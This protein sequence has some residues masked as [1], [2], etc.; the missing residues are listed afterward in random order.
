MLQRKVTDAND[1][2]TQVKGPSTQWPPACFGGHK[3]NVGPGT[4]IVFG[5]FIIKVAKLFKIIS[6]C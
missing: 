5:L 1:Q 6:N 3:G 4:F 2:W